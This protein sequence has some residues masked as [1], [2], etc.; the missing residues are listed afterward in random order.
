V[1]NITDFS[2]LSIPFNCIGTDLST[3]DVVVMD[4]GNISNCIRAS[5]AIP[6]VFTPG[7]YE[8]KTLV[9]GAVVNNFPVLEVKNMGAD[10]VIG[11][12]LYKGLEKAEDLESALEILMQIGSFKD[13]C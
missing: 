13:C 1:N 6:A 7:H 11:V 2:Q 5:L 3:G 8:N 4:H 9:D 10:I 12:N